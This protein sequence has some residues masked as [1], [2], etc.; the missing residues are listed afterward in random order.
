MPSSRRISGIVAVAALVTSLAL[1]V[2][3]SADR[4]VAIASSQLG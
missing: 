4:R 3:A 2:P 1:A